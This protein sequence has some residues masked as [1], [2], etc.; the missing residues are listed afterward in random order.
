MNIAL[1]MKVP[2][3]LKLVSKANVTEEDI[4]NIQQV[5]Y[6]T[7]PTAYGSI[8]SLEQ[9]TYML[10]LIYSTEAL[11][12][13]FQDNHSF[14][15]V[16]S[17]N[18]CTGFASYS[19]INKDENVYKLYKLYL[20]PEIQG[21]GIGKILLRRIINEVQQQNGKKISVNVNRYNAALQFYEKEGFVIVQ[22][23]DI[24]IGN[25]YYMN[26]YVLELMV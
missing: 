5:A 14:I 13:Q 25:G 3:Q 16:Y 20:L 2:T 21:K 11:A 7:W 26:D 19:L 4:K 12:Q 23:E 18:K 1:N 24:P 22:E 15:I 9:L 6:E 10:Q 8:L 17:D